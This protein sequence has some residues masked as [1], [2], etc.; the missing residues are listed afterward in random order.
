METDTVERP[1]WLTNELLQK[2]LRSREGFEQ[3]QIINSVVHSAVGKGENYTSIIF[4]I[5]LKYKKDDR[6][7]EIQETRFILK[8]LSNAEILVKFLIETKTFEKETTM[9]RDIIPSMCRLLENSLPEKSIQPLSPY[10]Y[11]SDIPHTLILE[12]LTTL[13]F[14]MANRHSRLDLQHTLIALK[15]LAKF[16][17]ASVAL[18]EKDPSILETFKTECIYIE[19]N[20][21]IMQSFTHATYDALIN[22][23]SQWNGYEKYIE[24]MKA[25]IPM[26]FD[27]MKEQIT[28]KQNSLNVLNHGDCWVNN[29]MFHYSP[30]SGEVDGI[31][32]IDFQ[33]S[34]FSSPAL[35]LQY[36][37]YTSP[38]EDV[39]SQKT[40]YLI[41]VYHK[42]LCEYL[43]M[44][45]Q[46]DKLI[47]LEELKKE[48]EEKYFFGFNTACTVLTAVLADPSE[49]FDLEHFKEDDESSFDPKYMEK[50][51]SGN[52]FKNAF[53]NLLPHFES[54]GAI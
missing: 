48:F 18:N 10:C 52:R 23:V 47:S 11:K 27:R 2:T 39:R 19:K 21:D 51:Y 4:R 32:F 43:K 26:Y 35:D 34:R 37:I 12:D 13:G 6:T 17:A 9:L 50:T 40:D 22:V 1:T 33:L 8:S 28:P 44:M 29:M 3:A 31:R 45:G 38:N 30:N 49:A 46:H 7:N 25:V 14:K 42:E 15:G 54:K 5:E 20:R 24:K 36:F 16:H 53:Q 41:E